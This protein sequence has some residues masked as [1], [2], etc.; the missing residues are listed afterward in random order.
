VKDGCES[1][2]PDAADEIEWDFESDP[3]DMKVSH[4]GMAIA[5]EG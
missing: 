5:P 3:W 2:E 1:N 4:C